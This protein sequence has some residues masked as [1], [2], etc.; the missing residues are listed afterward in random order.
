MSVSSSGIIFGGRGRKRRVLRLIHF[1][2]LFLVYGTSGIFEVGF[3][4]NEPCNMNSMA[5]K[6]PAVLFDTIN[7]TCM[8]A[9]ISLHVYLFR[10]PNPGYLYI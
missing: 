6:V 3:I 5:K 4:I 1:W 8:S 7:Q 10:H 9:A 2:S